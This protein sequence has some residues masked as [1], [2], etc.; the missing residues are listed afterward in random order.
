MGLLKSLV[1][2]SSIVAVLALVFFNAVS[3][4]ASGNQ[5]FH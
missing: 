2:R 1:Q 3:A 5:Y 4:R